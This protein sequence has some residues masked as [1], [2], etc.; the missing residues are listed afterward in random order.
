MPAC[1]LSMDQLYQRYLFIRPLSRG[2]TLTFPQL[3]IKQ[4]AS[5]ASFPARSVKGQSNHLFAS[6]FAFI[7]LEKIK[8]SK[9]L[10][11][12]AIK[13]KIYM[14]ALKAATTN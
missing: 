10:I 11:H 9:N 13:T 12:F 4:N 3:C 2:D 7:K 1:P 8:L 14:T 6:I 5:I